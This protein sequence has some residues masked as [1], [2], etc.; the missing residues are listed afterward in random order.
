MLQE[1]DQYAH[2][3]AKATRDAQGKGY[4]MRNEER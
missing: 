1:K 4:S 2:E 3:R